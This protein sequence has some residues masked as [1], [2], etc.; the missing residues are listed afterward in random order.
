MQARLHPHS[1]RPVCRA[2]SGVRRNQDCRKGHMW[3]ELTAE[4][5]I[6]IVGALCL[7]AEVEVLDGVWIPSFS[8]SVMILWIS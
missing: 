6:V 5:L 1:G 8:V 3:I 7:R 2:M 4:V